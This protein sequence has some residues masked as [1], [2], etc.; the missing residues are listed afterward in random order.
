MKIIITTMMT[1]TT[2]PAQSIVLLL[3]G[4]LAAGGADCGAE[5]VA[6]GVGAP[7]SGAGAG[8]GTGLGVG[9]VAA[10]GVAVGVGVWFGSIVTFLN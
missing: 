10:G 8:S 7:E 6:G 4:F 1:I 3:P 9:G 2:M 5:P